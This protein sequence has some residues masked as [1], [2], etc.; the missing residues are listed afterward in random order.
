MSNT[1]SLSAI[2]L[3]PTTPSNVYFYLVRAK[4]ACGGQLGESSNG[5][6]ITGTSCS[7][8]N[9]SGCSVSAACSSG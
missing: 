7:A 8:A 3:D 9:G 5:I 1:T 4:T 2:N 6:P